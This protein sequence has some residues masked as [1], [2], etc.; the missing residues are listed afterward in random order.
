MGKVCHHAGMYRVAVFLPFPLS[1]WILTQSCL[2]QN[3]YNLVYREEERE[4]VP[5]CLGMSPSWSPISAVEL[6]LPF[7]SG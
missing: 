2:V 3:L 4:M 7:V 1:P 5:Y 6:S